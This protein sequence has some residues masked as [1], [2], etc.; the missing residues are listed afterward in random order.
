MQGR[1][2]LQAS[3]AGPLFEASGCQTSTLIYAT[4]LVS[5]FNSANT[6]KKRT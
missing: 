2:Y 6:A 3:F 4:P 5:L 1:Q